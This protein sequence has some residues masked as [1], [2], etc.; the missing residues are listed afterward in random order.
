MLNFITNFLVIQI[1]QTIKI[2]SCPTTVS[3]VE[4]LQNDIQMCFPKSAC[5]ISLDSNWLIPKIRHSK[6]TKWTFK[7]SIIYHHATAE[8]ERMKI[9]LCILAQTFRAIYELY[10]SVPRI[11]EIECQFVHRENLI[12]HLIGLEIL[13]VVLQ[14]FSVLHCILS[15]YCLFVLFNSPNNTK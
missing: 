15:E 14:I 2:L 11:G 3:D 13:N 1:G 8:V 7:I 9:L 6:L 4:N 5:F 10:T 12:F